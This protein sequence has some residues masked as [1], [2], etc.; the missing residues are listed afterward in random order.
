MALS[1]VKL[2]SS[3]HSPHS[4]GFLSPL[5]SVNSKYFFL[6]NSMKFNS[7][8]QT[9]DNQRPSHDLSIY[10]NHTN[11]QNLRRSV[12]WTV[13]HCAIPFYFH[14]KNKAGPTILVVDG[15]ETW[16]LLTRKN[17]MPAPIRHRQNAANSHSFHVR[18]KE[19]ITNILE[20][21]W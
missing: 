2:F 21:A 3:H 1:D 7:R 17:L 16:K 13:D 5:H 19:V 18:T 11:C 14:Y 8:R 15:L 9:Y 10:I 12:E 6:H 20:I 4:W